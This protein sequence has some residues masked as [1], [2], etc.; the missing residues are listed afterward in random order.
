[1]KWLF[2]IIFNKY[3]QFCSIEIKFVVYNRLHH[4]TQINKNKQKKRCH[5]M[6]DLT[7][8]L[9]EGIEPSVSRL[10]LVATLNSRTP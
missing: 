1:M 9:P 6:S 4:T 3:Y 2:F 10:L 5:F 7:T 8:T